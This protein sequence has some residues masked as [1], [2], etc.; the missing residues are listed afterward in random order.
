[1]SVSAGFTVRCRCASTRSYCRSGSGARL[2]KAFHALEGAAIAR[3]RLGR[4]GKLRARLESNFW[5]RRP[6]TPLALGCGASSVACCAL[7]GWYEFR[8][9]SSWKERCEGA[10]GVAPMGFRKLNLPAETLS[11][12]ASWLPVDSHPYITCRFAMVLVSGGIGLTLLFQLPLI[13]IGILVVA[14][15]VVVACRK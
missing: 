3:R 9:E 4:V 10:R 13:R 5:T 15:S 1:M 2:F 8:Y 14:I 12:V 11:S 7:S 6:C